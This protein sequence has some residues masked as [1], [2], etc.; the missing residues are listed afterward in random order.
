MVSQNEQ[1]RQHPC[2]LQA[3]PRR[4]SQPPPTRIFEGINEVRFGRQTPSAR[5][6][7][8]PGARRERPLKGAA[9]QA[10]A[11][12]AGTCGHGT[13]QTEGPAGHSSPRHTLG[14]GGRPPRRIISEELTPAALPHIRALF[15]KGNDWE[16]RFYGRR[17]TQHRCRELGYKQYMDILRAAGGP[18]PLSVCPW[19]KP[20]RQRQQPM[21]RP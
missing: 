16:R 7:P 8:S 12:L 3:G 9:V 21:Q 4:L 11:G 13:A 6:S 14:G 15:A 5:A 20:D 10:S 18:T 17:L 1:Q 2:L 19:R